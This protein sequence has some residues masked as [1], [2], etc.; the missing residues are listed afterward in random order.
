MLDT[1]CAY[2]TQNEEE[3]NEN[4]YE[5]KKLKKKR[6]GDCAVKMAMDVGAKT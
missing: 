4:G 2:T 6:T 3:T 5:K 1:M